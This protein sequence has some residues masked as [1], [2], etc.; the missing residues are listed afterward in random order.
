[1]IEIAI[2]VAFAAIMLSLRGTTEVKDIPQTSYYDKP[3]WVFSYDGSLSLADDPYFAACSES[4]GN[5]YIGLSPEGDSI[6][7]DLKDIFGKNNAWRHRMNIIFIENDL[8]LKTM[9]FNDID[10]INAFTSQGDY[11]S[12]PELTLCLAVI[13]NKNNI[14]D[15]YEYSLM[16]NTSQTDGD[17]D[18]PKTSSPRIVDLEKYLT[19]FNI[20]H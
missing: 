3:D 9:Y 6:I 17:V 2:P 15:K 20:Y 14:N 10:A 11:A 12:S 18:I 1:M 13:V 19:L 8:N 4:R 16:F 5:S 7:S